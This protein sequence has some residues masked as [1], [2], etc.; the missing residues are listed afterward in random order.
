MRPPCLFL[1]QG[2]PSVCFGKSRLLIYLSAS[3]IRRWIT[4]RSTKTIRAAKTGY[5][6]ISS[7]L[8][9][10]GALIMALPDLSV[11]VIGILAGAML[12]ALGLVKLVGY[13][14]RDLYRLAFQ[15]DLAMGI[16]LAVM[17]VIL[18]ARP[19]TA[20]NFICV[21]LGITFLAD[22]LLKGQ[23]SL[24]ARRFGLKSWWAILLFGLFVGGV[25]VVL[26]LRPTQSARIMTILL[27]VCTLFEGALNLIVS[28]FAVKIIR[29]QQ[30]DVIEIDYDER[31]D[32]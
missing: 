25:G 32:L 27:G 18:L 11:S 30:P 6:I 14:S 28:L 3:R 15:F 16:L 24:D 2:R 29:H 4:V 17:G 8:M 31:K 19:H 7:L 1:W 22:G 10:L 12:V 9:V 26:V 20:M 5:I 23:M 21:A 13:F